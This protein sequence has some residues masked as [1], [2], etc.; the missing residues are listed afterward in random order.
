MFC[1]HNCEMG[2]VA[3]LVAH[4]IAVSVFVGLAAGAKTRKDLAGPQT[5]IG[6]AFFTDVASFS[7]AAI[8]YGATL[9][10]LSML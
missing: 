9:S 6:D 3:F 8:V 2:P 1:I 5:Q 4:K 10:A 7:A